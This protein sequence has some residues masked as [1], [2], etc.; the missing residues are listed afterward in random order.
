MIMEEKIISKSVILQSL[1]KPDKNISYLK[2]NKKPPT[3][4]V[5]L[6]IYDNVIDATD[7]LNSLLVG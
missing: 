4:N 2:A 6:Q 1:D 3:G 7:P 5:Y